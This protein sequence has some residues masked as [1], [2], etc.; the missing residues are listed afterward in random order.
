[1]TLPALDKTWRFKVNQTLA[2]TGVGLTDFQRLVRLIKTSLTTASGWTDS[3]NGAA[4][5][6]NPWTVT[7]SC[8]RSASGGTV[9]VADT[10]DNWTADSYLHW[11]S[12]GNA[13]AWIVLRQTQVVSGQTFEVCIDCCSGSAGA[14]SYPGQITVVASFAAGFNVSSPSTTARPTAT[15]EAA[16]SNATN[17]YWLPGNSAAFSC[18]LHVCCSDD[19]QCT[20]IFVMISG[21]CPSFWLFD[22]PKNAVTGW[23]YPAVTMALHQQNPTYA[24]LNDANWMNFR[25]PSAGTGTA[26]NGWFFLSTESYLASTALCAVGER[27]TVVNSISGDWPMTRIGLTSGNAGIYGRHGE[28]YDLWWG[29]TGVSTGDGYPASGTTKQFVQFHHLITPWNTTVPATS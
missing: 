25:A 17:V 10:N 8:A 16:V 19:G 23:A 28:L 26:I 14:D 7:A 24:L 1:M 20:R 11:N 15:D 29:S 27:I 6:T 2:T 22:Q 18:S 12:T 21:A 5:Y 13:H 3:S 4:T 9:W